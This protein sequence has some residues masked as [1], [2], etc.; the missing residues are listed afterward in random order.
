M[1]KIPFIFFIILTSCTKSNYKLIDSFEV[2]SS[3]NICVK[4]GGCFY[5]ENDS[6]LSIFSMYYL[7]KESNVGTLV[8]AVELSPYTSNFLI[9]RSQRNKSNVIIWETRSEYYPTILTYYLKKSSL[10]KIGELQISLPCEMCESLEYPLED[11]KIYDS[12]DQLEITFLK[13][14][15]SRLSSHENWRFYKAESAKYIFNFKTGKLKFE[16]VGN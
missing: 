16:K 15:N 4:R 14:V 12:K 7:D 5:F 9:F 6:S 11:L 2:N 1:Y 3:S 13:D 8:D 10:K